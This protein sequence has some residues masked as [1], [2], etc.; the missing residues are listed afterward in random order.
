MKPGSL[1]FKAF[2]VI[3]FDDFGRFITS[4]FVIYIMFLFLFLKLF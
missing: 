4:V 2:T 1:L 3:V